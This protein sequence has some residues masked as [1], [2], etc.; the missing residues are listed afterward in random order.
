MRIKGLTM[1]LLSS[2]ARALCAVPLACAIALTGVGPASAIDD[3]SVQS[4]PVSPTELAEERPDDA[5]VC[6]EGQALVKVLDS[7]NLKIEST[8]PQAA[9]RY[10]DCNRDAP[11]KTPYC[12]RVGIPRVKAVL[13]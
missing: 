13:S 4:A 12:F 2:K 6:T 11:A 1:K 9:G 3:Q 8:V 5:V 7:E 10:I